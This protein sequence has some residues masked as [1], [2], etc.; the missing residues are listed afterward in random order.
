MR[1]G[2]HCY[3]KKSRKG[4]KENWRQ[5]TKTGSERI[6]VMSV[7]NTSSPNCITVKVKKKQYKALVDT[8]AEV[9]IISSRVFDQLYPRPEL[10]KKRMKLQAAN[11]TLMRI[12]GVTSLNFKV[13]SQKVRQECVVIK[14]L[15]RLIILGR[16]WLRSYGVRVYF[17]LGAI[18][19]NNELIALEEDI[20]ITSVARLAE[21]ITLKPQHIHSCTLIPSRKE[22]EG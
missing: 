4:R 6:P 10:K 1:N 17:D 3:T 21:N 5:R 18:R 19:L 8:G 14:E 16:D 15:N 22:K 20:H 2:A 13:G 11:G 12:K 7:R 9:S